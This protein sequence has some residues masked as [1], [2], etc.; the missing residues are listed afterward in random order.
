MMPAPGVFVVSRGPPTPALLLVQFRSVENGGA[1]YSFVASS[2]QDLA[3]GQ[4]GRRMKLARGV[5]AA[6]VAPHP[7]RRIVQFRA[8]KRVGAAVKAAS[9]DQHRA[10]GQECRR[11]A[12]ARGGEAA[13]VAPSPSR[14][15]VQFRA[16]DITGG[17]IIAS[18]D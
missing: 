8:V 2:N 12:L 3:I 7:G 10:V 6:C 13:C 15:I 14:R 17:E 4:K 11:V 18:S 1:T 9:R 5:E 16:V